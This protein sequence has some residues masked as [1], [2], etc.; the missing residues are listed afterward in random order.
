MH[1]TNFQTS[2]YVTKSVR[3]TTLSL[4]IKYT[5]QK[6]FACFLRSLQ[7]TVMIN[8]LKLYSPCDW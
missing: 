3:D 2:A 5:I 4:N 7:L 1:Q 8:L 6:W